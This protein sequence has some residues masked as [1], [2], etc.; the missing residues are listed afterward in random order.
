[1]LANEIL[2]ESKIHREG[3]RASVRLQSRK[4]LAKPV[5]T[6]ERE[7]ERLLEIKNERESFCCRLR[8]E[9][10]AAGLRL[11]I[12]LLDANLCGCGAKTLTIIEDDLSEPK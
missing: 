2:G 6:I 3:K 11:I 12:N 4:L 9:F 8:H 7:R 10:I 1:M 5:V